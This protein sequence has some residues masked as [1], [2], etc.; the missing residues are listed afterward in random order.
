[1]KTDE[2]DKISMFSAF[3]SIF[4]KLL[5]LASL[6]YFVCLSSN[7]FRAVVEATGMQFELSQMAKWSFYLVDRKILLIVILIGAGLMILNEKI[8][9]NPVKRKLTS[10]TF[11]LILFFLQ[12]FMMN[13]IFFTLGIKPL[14]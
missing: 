13:S 3:F 7:S 9:T 14:L 4:D 5:A 10:Q 2:S 1:M 6:H 8:A 12:L 11:F